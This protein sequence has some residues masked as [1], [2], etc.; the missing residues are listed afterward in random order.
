MAIATSQ[1]SVAG[2]RGVYAHSGAHTYFAQIRRGG[3]L[4][5]LGTRDTVEE[6]A[7]LYEEARKYFDG[8]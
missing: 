5:Y 7:Q 2:I 4:H 6:A 1:P 3:K 8:K